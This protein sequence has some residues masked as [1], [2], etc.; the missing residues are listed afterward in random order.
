MWYD[1]ESGAVSGEMEIE[2]G[3]K[4]TD[5]LHEMWDEIVG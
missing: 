2:Q 3:G 1:Y 5:I 4:E